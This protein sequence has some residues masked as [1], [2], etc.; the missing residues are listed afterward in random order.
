[1]LGGTQKSQNA[2]WKVIN[3]SKACNCIYWE[4]DVGAAYK[5][6]EIDIYGDTT[7][8]YTFSLDPVPGQAG[9]QYFEANGRAIEGSKGTL[10]L[11]ANDG[12]ALSGTFNLQG[13]DSKGTIYD[14]K[15]GSFVKVAQ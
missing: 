1:M 2:R 15:E 5:N 6:I 8:T 14:I 9:F 4:G 7:G 10:K 11:S 3:G 13:R 12:S